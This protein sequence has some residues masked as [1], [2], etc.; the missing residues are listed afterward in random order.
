M[1]LLLS[2]GKPRQPCSKLTD[3]DNSVLVTDVERES[4]QVIDD[5]NSEAESC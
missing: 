2:D 3:F 5:E 1:I 4:V